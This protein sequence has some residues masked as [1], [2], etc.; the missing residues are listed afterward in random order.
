MS[1]LGHRQFIN[2]SHTQAKVVRYIHRA[3][4]QAGLDVLLEVWIL[5]G[6]I[7][8]VWRFVFVAVPWMHG[9]VESHVQTPDLRKKKHTIMTV[10]ESGATANTDT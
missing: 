1:V 7:S 3:S 8:K 2:V 10:D 5:G 9:L 6:Q 4:C